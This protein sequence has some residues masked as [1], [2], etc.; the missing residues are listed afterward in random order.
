M[1]FSR[2]VERK[3]QFMHRK[4]TFLS[5]TL[6]AAAGVKPNLSKPLLPDLSTASLACTWSP[7]APSLPGKP[8]N[9]VDLGLKKDP[10][11]AAWWIL[12]RAVGNSA[13]P[14]TAVCEHR[15]LSH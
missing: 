4:I 14:Q 15:H 12:D 7:T 3:G 2:L 13:E 8:L 11:F 9:K 6:E 10:D 5:T 1:T